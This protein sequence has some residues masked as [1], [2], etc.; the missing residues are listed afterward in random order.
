M[1]IKFEQGSGTEG[2]LK[3]SIKISDIDKETG[4]HQ[5]KPTVKI[6]LPGNPFNGIS[7][8][9]HNKPKICVSLI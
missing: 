7:A 4:T 8:T 1:H 9:T 2:E 6:S 3:P 5:R